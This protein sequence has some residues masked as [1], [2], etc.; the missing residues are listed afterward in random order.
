MHIWRDGE[1][2]EYAESLPR[3]GRSHYSAEVLQLLL[4]LFV[5]STPVGEVYLRTLVME[6]LRKEG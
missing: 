5:L 2:V 4:V 1:M 3:A 6:V